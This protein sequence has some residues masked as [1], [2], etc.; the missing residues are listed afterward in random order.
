MSDK[1]RI[2]KY[3]QLIAY[4]PFIFLQ[5]EMQQLMVEL[6]VSITSDITGS[7]LVDKGRLI[8][9]QEA[10]NT[11]QVAVEQFDKKE[12]SELP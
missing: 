5:K 1:E 3:R 6:M 2:E 10:I 8:G 9:I 12:D 4:E 11:P 7:C